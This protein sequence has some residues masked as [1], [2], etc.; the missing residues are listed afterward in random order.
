MKLIVPDASSVLASGRFR[1]MD[2]LGDFRRG[3]RRN[4]RLVVGADDGD[5][6]CL[7]LGRSVV[8]GA[9]VGDDDVVGERQRLAIGKKVRN[10]CRAG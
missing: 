9:A 3:R 2:L 4:D 5:S 1:L 7:D 10:P 8:A 6:D